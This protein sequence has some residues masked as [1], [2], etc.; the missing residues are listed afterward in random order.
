MEKENGKNYFPYEVIDSVAI[1]KMS[2]KP[3]NALDFEFLSQMK[4]FGEKINQDESARVV[5]LSSKYKVFGSGLDL[6][7][8]ARMG[9]SEWHLYCIALHNA[10]NKLDC[11]EKPVIGVIGGAAVG[12]GFLIA[13]GC[14]IRI[15]GEKHAY[16]SLPESTLG[17]PYLAGSTTRLPEIVGKAKAFELMYT[18]A[19]I[20]SRQA[21]NLGLAN[22]VFNDEELLTKS[23]EFAKGL[24]KKGR[25]SLAAAKKCL[26][27]SVLEQVGRNFTLEHLA[28]DM[29]AESSEIKEGYD[30]FFNKR[31]PDFIKNKP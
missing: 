28:V 30:S 9:K 31:E 6:K 7:M 3:V 18:G 15:M 10:F 8:A 23:F 21:L 11:I 2:S 12:G 17:I 14:D 29:T 24:A 5:M 20:N 27:Y 25:Y 19:K 22:W 4:K 13:L 26:N 1:V 16:L